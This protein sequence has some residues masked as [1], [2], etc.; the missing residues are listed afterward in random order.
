VFAL[1]LR[2]LNFSVSAAVGFIALIGIALLNAL[3]LIQILKDRSNIIEAA[4]LR[5][6]PVMMTA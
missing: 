4:S 2:G 3:V 1:W 5:L 6:R